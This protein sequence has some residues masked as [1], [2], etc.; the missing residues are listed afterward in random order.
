MHHEIYYFHCLFYYMYCWNLIYLNASNFIIV[1]FHNNNPFNYYSLS[2]NLLIFSLIFFLLINLS[3]YLALFQGYFHFEFKEISIDL[4]LPNFLFKF[5][6]KAQ[7]IENQTNHW[8]FHERIEIRGFMEIYNSS[9]NH[10]H[11]R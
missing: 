9:S 10:D 4:L 1:K 7:M 8:N 3:S 2:N 6:W 5:N 11:F